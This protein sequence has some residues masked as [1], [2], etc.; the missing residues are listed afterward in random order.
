MIEGVAYTFINLHFKCQLLLTKILKIR[1]LSKSKD[2]SDVMKVE[3]LTLS[4]TFVYELESSIQFSSILF[5][6]HKV[7]RKIKKLSKHIEQS[8]DPTKLEASLFQKM[9]LSK[10]Q[11]LRRNFTEDDFPKKHVT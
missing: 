3:M 1:R 5:D 8:I 10:G 9:H 11:L 4:A 7:H 6:I 2:L